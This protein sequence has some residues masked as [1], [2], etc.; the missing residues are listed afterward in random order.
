MIKIGPDWAIKNDS[1]SVNLLKRRVVQDKKSKSYGKEQWDTVGYFY[2]HEQ[3]LH[4]M[5]EMDIQGLESLEYIHTRVE[6]LKEWL[7]DSLSSL[8]VG[9]RSKL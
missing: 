8:S 3:A 7:A 5:I 1:Y 9:D 2:N 4:R 6:L